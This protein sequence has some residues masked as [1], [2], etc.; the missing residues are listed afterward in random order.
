M[1]VDTYAC[2]N[3][4]QNKSAQELTAERRFFFFFFRREVSIYICKYLLM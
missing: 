1:Y 2:T 3:T 4:F